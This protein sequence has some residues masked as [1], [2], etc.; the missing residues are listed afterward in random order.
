MQLAPF[1][2]KGAQLHNKVKYSKVCHCNAKPQQDP[3]KRCDV[4]NKVQIVKF[5]QCILTGPKRS[6]IIEQA[7]STVVLLDVHA[8]TIQRQHFS[9]KGKIG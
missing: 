8:G 4:S 7:P 3:N 6:I 9:E 5:N 1:E 2:G